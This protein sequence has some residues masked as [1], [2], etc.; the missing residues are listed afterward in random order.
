MIVR[1]FTAIVVIALFGLFGAMI[2]AQDRGQ[3]RDNRT[4]GQHTRFDAR[5]RENVGE[6]YREHR[7]DPPPG[8]RDGDH[9]TA[10]LES[11]LR[12]GDVL[13]SDLQQRAESVPADLLQILPASSP[14]LRYLVLDGHLLLVDVKTWN[15]CDVIHFELDFGRP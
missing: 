14:N 4:H 11:S 12:V 8:F 6:W 15:V 13:H 7:N 3:D 9:L 10:R 2:L 5:D 1:R